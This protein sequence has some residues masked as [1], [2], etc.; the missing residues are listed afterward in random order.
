MA[1]VCGRPSEDGTAEAGGTQPPPDGSRRSPST[2]ARSPTRAP[3]PWSRRSTRSP[4]TRRTGSAG[5]AAGYEYSRQ[6]EPDPGPRWRSAWPRWRAARRAL[7]FASGMAAEDCLLRT[8]CAPGDH[9]VIPHDAYGGTFRLFAKV[10]ADWGVSYRPVRPAD[11]GA[12]RRRAR[13]APGAGALG[14]D[15]DQPA[16]VAS[17]TSPRSR[18]RR[19]TRRARCWWWTTRSPRRTCSSRSRSARTWWSTPPPSTS[20]ATPTWSAARWWSPTRSSASAWPSCRTRPARWPARS[21]PG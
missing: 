3:A 7:A 12:V 4:P 9:V 21:T 19:R 1:D 5:C 6:R 10:L 13:R 8:V 20:A 11:L 2:P 17:R 16:A 14:G 15:A 18:E